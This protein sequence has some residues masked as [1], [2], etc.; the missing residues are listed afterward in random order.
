MASSLNGGWSADMTDDVD[1]EY[2]NESRR[3]KKNFFD[4]NPSSDIVSPTRKEAHSFQKSLKEAGL[5]FEEENQNFISVDGGVQKF[6]KARPPSG[7][8]SGHPSG[9]QSARGTTSASSPAVTTSTSVPVTLKTTRSSSMVAEGSAVTGRNVSPAT[10]T[11]S[12]PASS[13]GNE[14]IS[15]HRRSASESLSAGDKKASSQSSSPQSSLH[16]STQGSTASIDDAVKRD[17]RPS[18]TE[19]AKLQAEIHALHRK[20]K[21]LE[22][23]RWSAM[24]V[25]DTISRIITGERYSLEPYKSLKDKLSL[26]DAAIG[27]HDGNAIIAVVIFLKKTL[28]KSLFY[29]QLSKRPE[30]VNQYIAFIK[31]Y[32]SRNDSVA[33]ELGALQRADEAALWR[34]KLATQTKDPKARLNNLMHCNGTWFRKV[35]SLTTEHE[36]INEQVLL[37]NKQLHIEPRDRKWQEEGRSPFREMPRKTCLYFQPVI[38]TLFYCCLYHFNIQ[39]TDPSSPTSMKRDFKLTDKQFLFQAL[40]ARARLNDWSQVEALLTSKNWLG[41]ARLKAAVNFSQVVYILQTVKAPNE[42]IGRYMMLIEDQEARIAMAI[43]FKNHRVVIDTLAQLKDRQ[44]LIAYRP[45]CALDEDADR[46][47]DIVLRNSDNKWK[48]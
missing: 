23:S 40:L 16:G 13:T 8:F 38:T 33:N 9:F 43:K 30:A 46:H 20:I 45:K 15:V 34:Y 37:L 24:P 12:S 26:L 4:D 19:V 35:D 6:S 32:N 10:S 47:C 44:R 11:L 28:S 25:A 7:S 36:L 21:N 1:E 18:M 2:W 29:E 39:E 3:K 14:A 17:S 41:K 27:F 42:V 31:S 22:K 5:D 48:N